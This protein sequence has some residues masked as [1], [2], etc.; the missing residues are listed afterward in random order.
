[1]KTQPITERNLKNAPPQYDPAQNRAP[2]Q[3]IQA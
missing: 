3:R 2:E 1:M